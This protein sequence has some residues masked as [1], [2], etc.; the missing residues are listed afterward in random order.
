MSEAAEHF[1]DVNMSV[2]WLSWFIDVLWI[3]N[4]Y[5]KSYATWQVQNH[6][7]VIS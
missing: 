4:Q 5:E 6:V 1:M 7:G 2:K 3:F